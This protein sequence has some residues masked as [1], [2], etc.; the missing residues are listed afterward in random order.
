VPEKE[1]RKKN[2]PA[3]SG[4]GAE[5]IMRKSRKKPKKRTLSRCGRLKL[6]FHE[7]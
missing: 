4:K 3:A 2:Y 1:L 6:F 7:K 5:F